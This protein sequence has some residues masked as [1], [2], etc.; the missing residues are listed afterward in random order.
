MPEIIHYISAHR[1]QVIYFSLCSAEYSTAKGRGMEE[2][3]DVF[4]RSHKHEI[5]FQ[6]QHGWCGS[7]LWA[8]SSFSV[9]NWDLSFRMRVWIVTLACAWVALEEWK[10]SSRLEAHLWHIEAWL[11]CLLL[12]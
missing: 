2:L 8:P 10:V 9:G 4:P 3:S 11:S 7:N 12:M 1:G 5:H 6:S